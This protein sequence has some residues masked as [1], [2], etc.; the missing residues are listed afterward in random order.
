MKTQIVKR[1]YSEK[2]SKL[3]AKE[4]LQIE[5]ANSIITPVAVVERAEPESSPLHSYFE[6]NDGKAAQEYRIWQARQLISSVYL[7]NPDL[8]EKA[9][10]VRAF[11]NISPEPDDEDYP[12]L[13]R[14]YTFTPNISDKANYQH[15]VLQYARD[16]L[17]RWRRKFGN[18]EQFFGV[19]KAIDEMKKH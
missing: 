19:V 1:R 7:V 4:L 18:L 5:R 15:Q 14:G 2:E 13:G 12:E 10:P 6:W 9:E 8:D 16:Q 11:V 17:L 3:I